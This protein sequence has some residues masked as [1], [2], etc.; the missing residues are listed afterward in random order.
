MNPEKKSQESLD[1]S[2]CPLQPRGPSDQSTGRERKA[3]SAGPSLRWAGTALLWWMAGTAAAQDAAW[4]TQ[5]DFTPAER[6]VVTVSN[7][8]D[9]DRPNCPVVIRREEFPVQDLAEMLVTVVDPALPPA[10]APTAQERML[11]GPH[12]LQAET[13]GHALFRQLDDLDKD[14]I[15]DELYFTTDLPAHGT[16]TIHIYFGFNQRGWN[17]HG[18]HAGIGS[19]CRHLVPFWESAHIGWKLWFPGSVDVYAKRKGQLIGIVGATTPLLPAISSP[20]NVT[21][22]PN[23][24]GALQAEIDHLTANKAGAAPQ[25][26]NTD[27]GRRTGA[28]QGCHLVHMGRAGHGPGGLGTLAR[29]DWPAGLGE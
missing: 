14:G 7:P 13:H 12:Q 21:V 6:I 8:L 23:V 27:T 9:F 28:D 29:Q 24:V 20:R 10:A 11:G 5:G 4:Y 19:Y 22:D 17:P 15:W 25:R 18:S 2:I 26:H 3:S 1:G 16:K